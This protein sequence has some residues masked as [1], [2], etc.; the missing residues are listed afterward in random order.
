MLWLQNVHFVFN[1]KW[2]TTRRPEAGHGV[3]S[4]HV[5]AITMGKKW[6]CHTIFVS[7]SLHQSLQ[8]NRG[9]HL[10]ACT[11]QVRFSTPLVS[12]GIV[13]HTAHLLQ[14]TLQRASGT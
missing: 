9:F 10:K 13:T 5:G 1:S 7:G 12:I 6:E 4:A 3:E 11:H 14:K 2:D 8:Q